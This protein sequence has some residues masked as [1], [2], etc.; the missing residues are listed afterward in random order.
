MSTVFNYF[1]PSLSTTSVIERNA[2]NTINEAAAQAATLVRKFDEKCQEAHPWLHRL[3]TI[4]TDVNNTLV[5]ACSDQRVHAIEIIALQW[6]VPALTGYLV[7]GSLTFKVGCAAVTA[8]FGNIGCQA[9]QALP[10]KPQLPVLGAHQK[11]VDDLIQETK[12]IPG[13]HLSSLVDASLAHDG[14]KKLFIDRLIRDEITA[15]IRRPLSKRFIYEIRWQGKVTGYF[16][17]TIHEANCAMAEDP[18]LHETLKKCGRLI[19]ETDPQT[20]LLAASFKKWTTLSP[21]RNVVD[22]ELIRTASQIG[23][24]IEGLE[25][26]SYQT[27]LLQLF[28]NT[29]VKQDVITNNPAVVARCNHPREY[30]IFEMLDAYQRGDSQ[31]IALMGQCLSQEARKTIV[32][33]RNNKWLRGDAELIKRL[34]AD[35]TT[36]IL[37]PSKFGFICNMP[38]DTMPIGIGAGVLHGLGREDGMVW[39]L[40]REGLEVTKKEQGI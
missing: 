39:Q 11:A 32:T 40:R 9:L 30:Q 35:S 19:V 16:F 26:C 10:L 34:K 13:I 1:F 28:N 24:P 29:L 27:N 25:S 20:L 8:L 4:A 23:I 21:L 33:D 2:P 3:T 17:G 7:K 37:T 6:I 14:I 31:E 18:I 5:T 22:A 38:R 12:Q 15:I 36:S